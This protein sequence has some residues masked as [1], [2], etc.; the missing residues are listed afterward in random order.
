M[1]IIPKPGKDRSKV[2]CWRLMGLGNTAGKLGEKVV[3]ARLQK[4]LNL[5][6]DMQYGSKTGRWA[7]DSIMTTVSRAQKE[8]TSG[9]RVTLLGKDIVTALN[10]LR[11]DK[12]IPMLLSNN[13]HKEHAFRTDFLAPRKFQISWDSEERRLVRMD[14]STPQRSPLSRVL[15]P[16]HISQVLKN[17]EKR[18]RE[19]G[20]NTEGPQGCHHIR[21]RQ[22]ISP[23]P[24]LPMPTTL[25]IS[26][27]LESARLKNTEG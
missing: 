17:A 24:L 23:F 5:F 18:S 1:V 20:T 25:T 4:Q 15:W 12:I 14:A 6:P 13:L 11:K 2:N 22:Y 7:G 9:G 8:I 26:S 19:I 3:A 16:I 10:N 21:R 27:S